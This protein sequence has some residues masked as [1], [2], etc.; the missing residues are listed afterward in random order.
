MCCSSSSLAKIAWSQ[1]RGEKEASAA[2]RSTLWVIWRM[3][4]LDRAMPRK[5]S[6][7]PFCLN[8]VIQAML[9]SLLKAKRRG[10][11]S[12]GSSRPLRSEVQMAPMRMKPVTA[13]I[14]NG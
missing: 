7:T 2:V 4:W 8:I 1:Y 6:K 9:V 5:Y 13:T 11:R 14:S 3:D 10:D 12:N